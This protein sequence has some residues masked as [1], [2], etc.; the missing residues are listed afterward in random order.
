MI[1]RMHRVFAVTVS[2]SLLFV[3]C[4]PSESDSPPTLPPLTVTAPS[5]DGDPV[6]PVEVDPAL[7]E[8]LPIDRQVIIGSLENGLTYFVRENDS[9]GQRA[10]LRLVV[11]A[12]SVL[13]ESDQAGV[14]HYLE[15]MLFNGTEAFPKNDLIATLESFG[16][17]FGPDVNAYT[18]YDETVYELEIATD[19]VARLETAFDVLYQWAAAATLDPVDIDEERG[20]VIEEWRLRDQGIGG[21][22]S[23]SYQELLLRGTSYEGHAPIGSL[24]SLEA[25]DVEAIR[26]FYDTWYRPEMMAVVA[27]GD[28]DAGRIEDMITERFSEMPAGDGGLRAEVTERVAP[29]PRVVRLIDP[30]YPSAFVSVFF[31]APVGMDQATVGGLRSRIATDLALTMVHE[32]LSNDISRG[33]AA[34]FEVDVDDFGFVRTLSIIG[35]ELTAEPERLEA[36]LQ[37]GV[38][39]M[40]RVVQFGFSD[41]EFDRAR[42]RFRA[43]LDQLLAGKDTTQ[44]YEYADLYVAHFLD[45]D[46]IAAIEDVVEMSARI[47]D[48]MTV[49]DVQNAVLGLV[50]GVQPAVLLVA[51]A[52]DEA[53][54]LSEIDVLEVL[55]GLD[56]ALITARAPEVDLG[57]RLMATPEPS[58][59]VERT[60]NRGLGFVE[61][62]LE[63]GVRAIFKET[64]ISENGFSVQAWSPGGYSMFED[65]SVP[66]AQLIGDIVTTSGVGQFDQV[67]L[68]R[69]LSDRLVG[70]SVF[71]EETN[72]SM[73]GQSST[74]DAETLFQLIHLYMTQPR[75]DASAAEALL[76]QYRPYAANPDQVP[77]LAQS[78]ALYDARYGD[79]VRYRA[80]PTAGELAA[81]DMEDGLDAYRLAVADADD[82]CVRVRRRFRH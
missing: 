2:L 23:N 49:A 24:A 31:S 29:S 76:N 67:A 58:E 26:R 50:D 56:E 30:E 59:I 12:G 17:Q 69:I 61:I 75:A 44:D 28:F 33:E 3:A 37:A 78:I 5:V 41:V 72:D 1:E 34:F 19:R 15:H 73:F 9:P 32:R 42:E 60:S 35:I 63:N 77:S 6:V 70:L 11:N 65:G 16:A 25:L 71:I 57:D 66:G 81:F 7:L 18:S 14:A 27:V 51:P 10:Q 82:W 4:T 80:I 36:S 39:E 54:V 52:A 47:V 40:S 20:V 45:G 53:S 21:R 79:E 62:E 46:P 55:S 48:S 64:T 68:E 43:S 38:E 13:E 22:I 8:P 74:D